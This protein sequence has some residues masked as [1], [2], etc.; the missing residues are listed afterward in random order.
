M[1]IGFRNNYVY[2]LSSSTNLSRLTI[3]G[4]NSPA[5]LQFARKTLLTLPDQ[6]FLRDLTLKFSFYTLPRKR[7]NEFTQFLITCPGLSS[8]RSV[9]FGLRTNEAQ[10]EEGTFGLAG[11]RGRG[12]EASVSINEG[13]TSGVKQPFPFYLYSRF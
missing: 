9:H 3:D 11:L 8:L 2:S 10:V 7:W 13:E 4:S 5:A 12:W 1:R 6:N